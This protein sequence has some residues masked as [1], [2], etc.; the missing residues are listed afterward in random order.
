MAMRI[1]FI[2][3]KDTMLAK[4]F[5]GKVAGALYANFAPFDHWLEYRPDVNSF[6]QTEAVKAL[7]KLQILQEGNAAR[8][9]PVGAWTYEQYRIKIVVNGA[10]VG[11]AFIDKMPA[12]DMQ[13]ANIKRDLMEAVRKMEDTSWWPNTTPGGT[14]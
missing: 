14:S 7:I 11:S 2:E 1:S 3:D 8:N 9:A 12:G 5:A 13:V 10:V 4:P 6:V